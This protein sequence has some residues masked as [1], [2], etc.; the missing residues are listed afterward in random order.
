[1]G[2]KMEKRRESIPSL[3]LLCWISVGKFFLIM[4][5]K[6]VSLPGVPE[7]G[8]PGVVIIFLA[9]NKTKTLLRSI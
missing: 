9:F 5:S 4:L 3:T 2:I 7:P 6:L 1:M 8:V